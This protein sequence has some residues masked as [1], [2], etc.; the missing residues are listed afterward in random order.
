M[1]EKCIENHTRTTRT[2][3]KAELSV[4]AAKNR[5]NLRDKCLGDVALHHG[6]SPLNHCGWLPCIFCILCMR[7][8]WRFLRS[9]AAQTTCTHRQLPICCRSSHFTGHTFLGRRYATLQ[10]EA[11]LAAERP[12]VQLRPY[13][14]ECIEAVLQHL[15]IGHKR[16]G[17][18]LATGSGKTV[19]FSHLIDRVPSPTLDATQTL[20]LVHRRELVEQAARH[21]QN[22]Y[23]DKIIDIEMG[24]SHASGSADIT[25]ASVQSIMSGERLQKFLPSRFKLLLVDEAHHI[26]AAR[27]LDILKHFG[28]DEESQ[29]QQHKQGAALVGV[30]ATFSRHDGLR[31]GA[32]ID[33]IV[34]HKY[35]VR[36][37][38]MEKR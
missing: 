28:L 6:R 38:M 10:P 29:Q 27:Y 3:R 22:T 9:S 1:N 17:I 26:V 34:Y 12:Q 21:C 24:S 25:V 19:V 4:R 5:V 31:L 20:I 8:P 23:P 11:R 33:H 35:V 7:M 36:S 32:A 30:S 18:S 14:D 37:C 2:N 15:R 13:Q 16:L